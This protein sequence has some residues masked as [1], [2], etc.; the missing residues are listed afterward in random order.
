MGALKEFENHQSRLE[1][2]CKRKPKG[3]LDFALQKTWTALDRVKC[4]LGPEFSE[5]V[6]RKFPAWCMNVE[7]TDAVYFLKPNE[8]RYIKVGY[9]SDLT[10]RMRSYIT[11]YPT[12]PKII[13]VLPGGFVQESK[14]H[15]VLCAYHFGRDT[16]EW[17]DLSIQK[18]RD[19]LSS[20]SIA[21]NPSIVDS[22]KT[23][24]KVQ[25]SPC[26]QGLLF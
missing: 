17:F 19:N 26:I 25:G 6:A 21:W 13:G 12:R 23:K 4:V 22:N 16:C 2:K 18:L 15:D 14:L 20:E 8:M 10:S 1:L 9:T 11:Y 24:R 5:V 3:R 7:N